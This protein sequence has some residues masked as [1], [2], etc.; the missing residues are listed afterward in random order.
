MILT[1]LVRFVGLIVHLLR[2]GTSASLSVHVFQLFVE[3]LDLQKRARH[4]TDNSLYV[5]TLIGHHLGG[6]SVRPADGA[7]KLNQLVF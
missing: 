1:L 3:H 2:I 6:R 4:S 7:L 5:G